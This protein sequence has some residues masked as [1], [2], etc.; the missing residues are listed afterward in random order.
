MSSLAEMIAKLGDFGLVVMREILGTG[1]SV[2]EGMIV[3][4]TESPVRLVW[5]ADGRRRPAGRPANV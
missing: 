5:K 4:G 1:V 3:R 2:P